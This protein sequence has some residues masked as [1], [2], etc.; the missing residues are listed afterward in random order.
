MSMVW[1]QNGFCGLLFQKPYELDFHQNIFVK[2][3]SIVATTNPKPPNWPLVFYIHFILSF[4]HCMYP[5]LGLWCFMASSCYF[6]FYA[7]FQQ[8]FFWG[9]EKP[10]NLWGTAIQDV[11]LYLECDFAAGG[12]S[13]ALVERWTAV[14]KNDA[15]GVLMKMETNCEP[16]SF[17]Y[18]LYYL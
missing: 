3:S 16:G 4:H 10:T 18:P 13:I 5:F 7:T 17:W 6:W 12:G 1:W 2:H 14:G 9:G 15:L 11:V 8:T